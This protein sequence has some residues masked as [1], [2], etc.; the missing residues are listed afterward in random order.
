MSPVHAP[1]CEALFDAHG[2]LVAFV[3]VVRSAVASSE[4]A[5]DTAVCPEVRRAPEAGD[6]ATASGVADFRKAFPMFSRGEGVEE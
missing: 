6:F 4:R 1:Q 5:S 3:P 2:A